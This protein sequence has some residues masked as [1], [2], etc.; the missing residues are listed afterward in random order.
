MFF[1]VISFYAH[2]ISPDKVSKRDKNTGNRDNRNM[3]L[4]WANAWYLNFMVAQ[5]TLRTDGQKA[6]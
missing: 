2:K 4:S 6:E 3:N 5:N 1:L